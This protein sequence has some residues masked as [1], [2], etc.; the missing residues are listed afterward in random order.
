MTQERVALYQV[1]RF[2]Q[3]HEGFE[4]DSVRVTLPHRDGTD[5]FYIARMRSDARL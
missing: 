4:A 2:L 3:R 5:G 1:E